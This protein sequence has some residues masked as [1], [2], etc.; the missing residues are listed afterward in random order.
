MPSMDPQNEVLLYEK[1]PKDV[2]ARYVLLMDPVLGSG[3]TVC[4]AI[5]VLLDRGV[6][7]DRIL[8]LCLIASPQGVDRVCS[9]Y[10]HL[11]VIVSAVDNGVNSVGEVV[12]GIG[13]FADRYFC[14]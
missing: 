10:P 11:K 3:D 14:D 7:E 6:K 8:F 2:D 13:E 5:Q 9:N 1:L 12:P 4:R